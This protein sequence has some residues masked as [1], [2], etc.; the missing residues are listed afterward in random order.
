MEPSEP[1]LD[2]LLAIDIS[3]IYAICDGIKISL[4]NSNLICLGH[5]APSTFMTNKTPSGADR[6]RECTESESCQ[7]A[8]MFF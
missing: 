5:S 1:P 8:K 7:T 4:K 6:H 3:H 2:L